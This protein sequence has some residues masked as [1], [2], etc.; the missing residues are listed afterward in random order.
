[1]KKHHICVLGGTGFLGQALVHALATEGHEIVVPSR[2]PERCREL[3]LYPNVSM[4]QANIHLPE[5]LDELF[6]NVDTV[7]NLVDSKKCSGSAFDQV[8]AELTR[9]VVK[10]CENNAV[11]RLLQWSAVSTDH[12][13]PY[14]ASK[15][16]AEKIALSSDRV[17][18]T[19][20][21]TSWLFGEGTFGVKGDF[22]SEIQNR[23]KL[24]VAPFSQLQSRAAPIYFLDV[25]EIFKQT[26]DNPNT[27][28]Q[29]LTLC[30]TQSYTLKELVEWVKEI[31]ESKTMI[32]EVCS[33]MRS[34]MNV[35]ARD[36]IQ[37]FKVDSICEHNDVELFDIELKDLKVQAASYLSPIAIRERYHEMRKESGR[38]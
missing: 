6:K 34:L 18:T 36:V 35:F 3:S 37:F 22:L 9:K 10:A 8:H 38:S 23:L 28:N 17:N 7:I 27:F 16:E 2:R 21:K 29:S 15:L 31:T 19:V 24:P 12:T 20:L 13:A 14:F 26:I 32:R 30:G 25:V 4:R 33:P 11:T 1:M 5:V